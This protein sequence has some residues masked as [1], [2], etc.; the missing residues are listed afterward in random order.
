M[1]K[2]IHSI[3]LLPLKKKILLLKDCKPY[4]GEL[5]HNGTEILSINIVA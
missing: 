5:P 2:F 3:L 4:N 1:K